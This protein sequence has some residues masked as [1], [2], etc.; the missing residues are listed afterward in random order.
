[1]LARPMEKTFHV[2]VADDVPIDPADWQIES[3]RAASRDA[4]AV[5]FPEPLDRSLVE[6]M[7]WVEN[8]AGEKLAG[9]IDV[10]DDESRWQFVPDRPWPSGEYRLVV[11]TA[12]EDV[13]GNAV[14]RAFDVD[15]FGPIQ[16]KIETATVSI[17]FAIA[18]AKTD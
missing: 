9:V 5:R 14:G 2:L 13:A 6:R 7:L 18:A 8:N 10:G 1:M 4:L 3:P 15:T 17:R 16:R 12:L 11:D